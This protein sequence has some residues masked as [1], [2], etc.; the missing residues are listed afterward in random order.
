[1]VVMDT[2]VFL[3]LSRRD[4]GEEVSRWVSRARTD[5]FSKY[6]VVLLRK[7]D[8]AWVP[9]TFRD[10]MAPASIITIPVTHFP[11]LVFDQD[12]VYTLLQ[13]AVKA[14]REHKLPII[15]TDHTLIV[16]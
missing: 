10:L 15:T 1:M 8:S 13:D 4:P 2:A 16:K 12:K 6:D 14:R 7:S 5:F 3:S 9:Y 11:P